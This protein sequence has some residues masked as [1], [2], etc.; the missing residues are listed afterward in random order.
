[1]KSSG[2]RK[3]KKGRGRIQPSGVRRLG[4]S[5]RI[6]GAKDYRLASSVRVREARTK[7]SAKQRGVIF[8][9]SFGVLCLF[10]SL[11]SFLYTE[12]NSRCVRGEP[13]IVRCAPRFLSLAF[14]SAE[15]LTGPLSFSPFSP[16]GWRDHSAGLDRQGYGEDDLR[17]IR[18][19]E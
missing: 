9:E 14:H 19:E 3:G 1:M 18:V 4:N 10:L 16:A 8:A 6:T 17:K 13:V 7:S 5:K 11:L 12:H 2:S 15:G